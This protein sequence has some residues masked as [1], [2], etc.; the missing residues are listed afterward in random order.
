LKVNVALF[1]CTV[2]VVL[3]AVTQ[4][5]PLL[6]SEVGVSVQTGADVNAVGKITSVLGPALTVPANW[7]AA[8]WFRCPLRVRF[9]ML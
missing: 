4:N 5:L 1:V 3:V 8:D 7:F 6:I 9:N 2:I